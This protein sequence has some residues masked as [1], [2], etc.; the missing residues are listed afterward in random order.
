MCGYGM[1]G[2]VPEWFGPITDA[3]YQGT[4]MVTSGLGSHNAGGGLGSH[5]EPEE[6]SLAPILGQERQEM[7]PLETEFFASS[8][9][10]QHIRC[11]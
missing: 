10:R 9:R 6:S 5:S 4:E 1:Q 11:G 2:V 8:Q 7:E 3:T